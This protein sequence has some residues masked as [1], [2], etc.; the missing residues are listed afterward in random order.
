MGSSNQ[1]SYKRTGYCEMNSVSKLIQELVSLTE[2]IIQRL[3]HISYEELADFSD[4]REKLVEEMLVKQSDLTHSD[5]QTLRSLSQYDNQ[6]LSKM[7]FFKDE[8]S[9]WLLRQG[10]R[11]EQ[12]SAYKINYT[13]DSMFLDFKK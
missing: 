7:K 10:E 6:I 4:T 5:K 13:P 2:D 9:N 1:I 8:A 12:Q 3:D 11:R